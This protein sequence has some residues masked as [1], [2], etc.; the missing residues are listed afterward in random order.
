MIHTTTTKPN[1]GKIKVEVPTLRF[2]LY[3]KVVHILL[4]NTKGLNENS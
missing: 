3:F 1:I 4:G 2:S